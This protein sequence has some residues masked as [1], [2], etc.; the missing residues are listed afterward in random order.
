MGIK[1]DS[2]VFLPTFES[3]VCM[4][5]EFSLFL[6][7]QSDPEQWNFLFHGKGNALQIFLIGICSEVAEF[8]YSRLGRIAVEDIRRVGLDISEVNWK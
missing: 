4:K 5:E 7:S 6:A 2:S 3:A 1:L 8:I